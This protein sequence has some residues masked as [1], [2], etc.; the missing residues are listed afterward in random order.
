VNSFSELTRKEKNTELL[1]WV[2]V[3][4]AAVIGRLAAQII[5]GVVTRL[6]VNSGWFTLGESQFVHYLQILVFYSPKE[7]A[8]VIAGAKM[9]PRGRL[10][11]TIVLAVA[12]ILMSLIVHVLGQATPGVVNYTHFAAEAAG[13][14]SGAVYI[15]FSRTKT[16]P[17]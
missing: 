3:L 14:V 5:I 1:R 15:F 7:A 10:A 16:R 6:A 13:A 9:A 4:P 17:S 12:G 11:T 2:S 8:F